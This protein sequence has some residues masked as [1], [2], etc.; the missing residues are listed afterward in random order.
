M[1]LSMQCRSL[2]REHAA[3]RP[4]RYE[5]FV[6]AALRQWSWSK[7]NAHW[8]ESTD[9]MRRRGELPEPCEQCIPAGRSSLRCQPEY[10][11]RSSSVCLEIAVLAIGD[12]I[13]FSQSLHAHLC[14]LDAAHFAQC[15]LIRHEE[16][17][18]MQRKL[19]SFLWI[20]PTGTTTRT[21]VDLKAPDASSRGEDNAAP[22]ARYAFA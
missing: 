20:Q 1:C 19:I 5:V 11:H 8:W 4:M 22:A 18:I 2:V 14:K 9:Q 6:S 15:R 13:K 17:A 21:G 3:G 16:I 12:I 7:R 10:G